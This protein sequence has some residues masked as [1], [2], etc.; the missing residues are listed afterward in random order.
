ML[1]AVLFVFLIV[2]FIIISVFTFVAVTNCDEE[3]QDTIRKFKKKYGIIQDVA[4][5]GYLL[6][7]T[8]YPSLVYGRVDMFMYGWQYYVM[9]FFL[10]EN[11]NTVDFATKQR[12]KLEKLKEK[13]A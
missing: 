2:S 8:K 9:Q 13:N 5:C 11:A 7:Q 3:D 12:T 6:H 1:F 4:L 10:D